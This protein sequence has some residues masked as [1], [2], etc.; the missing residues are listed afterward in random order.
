M[1]EGL[2]LK[3]TMRS[4][5]STLGGS[6]RRLRWASPRNQP[7][8]EEASV[9]PEGHK[10]KILKKG[11]EVDLEV[12]K[13]QVAGLK[14][15]RGQNVDPPGQA[16]GPQGRAAGLKAPEDQEGVEG[17]WTYLLSTKCTISHVG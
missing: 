3:R 9:D 16:V 2:L 15:P 12:L 17:V 7:V 13:G 6:S 8:E 4:S 1:T 14:A 5:L 10:L 11:Q